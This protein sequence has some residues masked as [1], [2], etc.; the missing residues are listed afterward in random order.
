VETIEITA[1]ELARTARRTYYPVA[2]A[3]RGGGT[4]TRFA[5][6]DPRFECKHGRLLLGWPCNACGN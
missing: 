3:V 4:V 1:A 2:L 5:S 6:Y